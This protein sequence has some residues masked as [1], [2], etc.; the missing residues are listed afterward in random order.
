[1]VYRT[2]RFRG[3]RALLVP[4]YAFVSVPFLLFN[5]ASHWNCSPK[6]FKSAAG[7][8]GLIVA[9]TREKSTGGDVSGKSNSCRS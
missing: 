3:S 9:T 1:V 4:R 2:H 5:L 8:P 7:R 6:R